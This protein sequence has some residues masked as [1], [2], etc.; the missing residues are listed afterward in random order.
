MKFCKFVG[1]TL[2][3]VT[4]SGMVPYVSAADNYISKPLS[5]ESY[6]NAAR[7]YYEGNGGFASSGKFISAEDFMAMD[8][9]K[10][11]W[12]PIDEWEGH[13]AENVMSFDGTDYLVKIVDPSVNSI[14]SGFATPS[15]QTDK[16]V[17][18]DIPDGN[19]AGISMLGGAD[20][21]ASSLKAVLRFNYDDG[22]DSGWIEYDQKKVSAESAD[23][24]AVKAK[25]YSSGGAKDADFIYLYN[26]SVEADK[27]KTMTTVDFLVRNALL[28]SDGTVELKATTGAEG[29]RYYSRYAAISMLCDKAQAEKEKIREIADIIKTLPDAESF[30]FSDENVEKLYKIRTIRNT[31]DESVITDGEDKEILSNADKYIKLLDEIDI[32]KNNKIIESI[33]EKLEELPGVDDLTLDDDTLAKFDEISTIY[34]TVDN[35]LS[36]DSAHQEILDKYLQYSQK[37]KSLKMTENDKKVSEM[38]K[39]TEL[40]PPIEEFEKTETY[41]DEVIES[42]KKLQSILDTFDESA[43]VSAENEAA[44]ALA[45]EYVSKIDYL[46]VLENKAIM[47]EIDKYLSG[48]PSEES[49]EYTRENETKL[50]KLENLAA[51]LN[52]EYLTKE[53]KKT[54]E[55]VNKYT[56]LLKNFPPVSQM[57]EPENFVNYARTFYCDSPSAAYDNYG[58]YWKKYIEMPEWEEPWKISSNVGDNTLTFNGVRYKLRVVTEDKALSSVYDPGSGTSVGYVVHNVPAGKYEGVSFLGGAAHAGSYGAVAFNYSDGTS[59]EFLQK[60]LKKL[61]VAGS[62][63]LKIPAMRYDS[64]TGKSS[65]ADLYLYQYNFDNP[66]PEKTVVSISIPFRNVTITDG[67]L[68]INPPSGGLAYGYWVR[69]FGITML[70]STKDYKA[71]ISEKFKELASKTDISEKDLTE[72]DELVK[73]A[74]NNGIDVSEIDGYDIY[75]EKGASVARV[76]RYEKSADLKY[77]AVKVHFGSDVNISKENVSLV[78][79]ENNAVDFE[80]TYE[81]RVAEIKFKN[82]FD[83]SGEYTLKLKKEISAN[84]NSMSADKDYGFSIPKVLAFSD[85]SVTDMGEN[86]NVSFTLNNYDIDTTDAMVSICVADAKGRLCDSAIVKARDIKKGETLSCEDLSLKMPEGAKLKVFV[87][88]NMEKMNTVYKYEY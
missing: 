23:A 84:G 64:S 11:E 25:K 16:F 57:I 74:E 76:L 81:N 56:A 69:W 18:I 36:I 75:M 70:Q 65:D 3:I 48:L 7:N 5:Q 63:A 73:N 4:V 28:N 43:G 15:S 50:E 47:E 87:L 55:K 49:F 85:F 10:N 72:A 79:P 1:G 2:C 77:A 66:Y 21:S 88:D 26:I 20:S 42:L 6:A 83:Y 61:N 51:K 24:L 37:I 39:I 27:E 35:T 78:D 53:Q 82:S 8:I 32:Q 19:Y 44:L 60:N 38:K 86:V 40:L 46:H 45:K 71:I 59:S 67:K 9:W 13:F 12:K 68:T 58:V 52:D 54:L 34:E 33:G 22:T 80:L 17:T 29:Y 14:L 31:V 62:D 30:D 41:T